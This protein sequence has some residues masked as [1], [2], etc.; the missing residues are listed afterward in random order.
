VS[1]WTESICIPETQQEERRVKTDT[2][3]NEPHSLLFLPL[4]PPTHTQF[5]IK[6][7]AEKG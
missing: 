2:L 7:K 1:G 4:S 3:Q 5:I 6:A